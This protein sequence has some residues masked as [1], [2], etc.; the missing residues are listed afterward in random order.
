MGAVAG[1]T[2]TFYFDLGSPY[3]WLVAERL[4]KAAPDVAWQ[5][6]EHE[7]VASGPLWDAD[8][9]HVKDLAEKLEV[10]PPRWPAQALTD[11]V[12]DAVVGT[13]EAMLMATYAKSIGRCVAFS[14]A[15]FR[16]IYNA[17]RHIG[18]Q[19]TLLLAAAACE[20]HPR[21]VLKALETRSVADA[22]DAANEAARA[23]GVRQLPALAGD[24]IEAHG[25]ALLE[26]AL[27]DF[28]PIRV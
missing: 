3:A 20:M 17:G 25:P 11:D 16:Q 4:C 15:A 18:D 27:D 28:A 26:L 12:S 23:S 14:L 6:V 1:A 5:P 22:L 10:L 9:D 7:A 24:G 19:D 8:R 13:R 2:K 21:A